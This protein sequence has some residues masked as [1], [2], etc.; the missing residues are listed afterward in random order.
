MLD[1]KGDFLK[2]QETVEFGCFKFTVLKLEG[3]RI[4]RVKVEIVNSQ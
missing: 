3:Y 2:E 1:I 4:D